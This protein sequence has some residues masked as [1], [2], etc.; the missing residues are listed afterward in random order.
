[1]IVESKSKITLNRKD[2]E[3]AIVYHLQNLGYK[4]ITVPVFNLVRISTPLGDDLYELKS[5]E[6]DIEANPIKDEYD[7]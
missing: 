1:M 3:N 7:K 2:V 6:V 4:P 5:A